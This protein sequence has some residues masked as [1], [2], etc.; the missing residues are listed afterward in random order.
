MT[1][2]VEL[3]HLRVLLA[4][5]D[6]GSLTGAAA[7]LGI[8]Q[9]GVSRA[10]AQLEARLG[11]RLVHRTTR[12]VELTAAGAAFRDAAARALAAVDEGVAAVHG[13]TP[14][15]RVGFSWAA[16]GRYT[17]PVLRAW[18]GRHPDRPV[19]LRRHDDR[20]AG[21]ATGQ[22]DLAL[23][24]VRLDAARYARAELF[25]EGRCVAVAEGHPLAD[26]AEL[27]LADLAGRPMAVTST[28][29]TTTLSLWP[30]GQRPVVTVDARN[31][32]DWLAV[33]GAGEA[34]GV[35][36]ESTA[37]QHPAPG[38]RYV[39]LVDAPPVVA[40]F[41]WRRD[42]VH[43]WSRAFVTTAREVVRGRGGV[44]EAGNRD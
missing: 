25:R 8:G 24:R 33:V 31:V 5:G 6:S 34:L 32:D 15:L 29:G 10:L 39:P 18:R 4:I 14:P 20:T 19:E 2:G 37:H 1:D 13:L 22:T 30:P 3:R 28:Y 36:V 38:V 43:P 44:R 12:L 9:P 35:T 11:V 26:R 23:V 40:W 16:A 27:H 7:A 21:L 42:Q 41:A 17:L